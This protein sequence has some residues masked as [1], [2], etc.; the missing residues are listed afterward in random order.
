MYPYS[1]FFYSVFFRI[2][3]E[4]RDLQ[5]EFPYSVRT[6]ENQNQQKSD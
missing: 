3:T 2:P 4:Q 6:Q 5:R 1:E